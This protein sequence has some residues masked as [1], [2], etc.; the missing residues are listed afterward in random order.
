MPF[1]LYKGRNKKG[2]LVKGVLESADRG[3][4]AK[5]LFSIDITPVEIVPTSAPS[6]GSK[7][8]SINLFEERVE[9]IDIM[10]FSRQMYT[11]LKAGI[12]IMS[13]LSGL[14]S[15]TKSKAL[16]KVISEIRSSL[17]SGR[18]LSAALNQHPKVFSGFYVS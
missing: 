5:H 6:A 1:F 18:E 15:S 17:D 11:L 7:D 9:L 10:M 16:S 13:A 3:E 8:L 12:P 14:L 2:E 4:L